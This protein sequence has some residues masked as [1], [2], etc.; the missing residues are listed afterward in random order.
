MVAHPPFPPTKPKAPYTMGTLST[1]LIFSKLMIFGLDN[2]T[3]VPC[4]SETTCSVH[5]SE[6]N[7]PNKVL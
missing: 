3:E 1:S 7:K 4:T 6:Q 5:M 2:D